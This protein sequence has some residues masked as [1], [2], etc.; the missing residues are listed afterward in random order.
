MATIFDAIRVKAP[1]RNKFDLSHEKKLTLAMGQLVPNFLQEV[2][3]GDT[4]KVRTEMLT[5]MQPLTSPVMHKLDVKQYF[6]FVPNRI[7]YDD[8]EDFITGGEKGDLNPVWPHFVLRD[9][10]KEWFAKYR[11]PDYFG[12]PAVD[13]ASTITAEQPFSALPFRA[14]QAIYN[15]YFRQQWVTDEITYDKGSGEISGGT[16]IQVLT[17]PR[18]KAWEK[19]YF[20]TALP[21][22]QKGGEAIIPLGQIEPDYKDVSDWFNQDGTPAGPSGTTTST[23]FA[24]HPGDGSPANF[25]VESIDQASRVENL[26]TMEV[27]PT[28][29]RDL[30]TAFRLQE[31]L[32][33]SAR[34]GSRYIE[35]NLTFWGVKSSDARLQRPEY[36]GGFSSPIAIS[37][38]LNT[39]GDIAADTLLPVGNMSGHGVQV[40]SQRGFKRAFE[41]HGLILGIMCVIPRT[42]YFQGIHRM[43]QRQDKY[44]YPWPQFAHIGEQEIANKELYYDP[45]EADNTANDGVFGYQ[46]RY[47]EYKT[48]CSTVHGD[49]KGDNVNKGSLQ[50]WHM[51]RYFTERPALNTNFIQADPTTDIFAVKDNDQQILS[52]IFFK[53]SAIRPIPYYTDPRI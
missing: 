4:F 2:L 44:D 52:Q 13:Q 6:F 31:W 22:A 51:G 9:T 37:E 46:Q 10:N 7:I 49:F 30:R 33:L 53:V 27:G 34:G 12:I 20:T 32:E 14:Y 24:G 28:T 19:D 38:V 25:F 41:E 50:F 29:I 45:T 17:Q 48:G 3:P 35:Q 26:N 23:F 1:G 43:W 18:K 42:N 16:Q 11:L 5:R 39:A 40:S 21:E 47:A 15:E 36:L 8:W